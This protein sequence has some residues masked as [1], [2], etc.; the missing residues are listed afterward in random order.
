M[1]E[2]LFDIIKWYLI[3]LM[4]AALALCL[5]YYIFNYPMR[6]TIINTTSE[7]T[8]FELDRKTGEVWYLYPGSGGMKRRRVQDRY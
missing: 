1:K 8:V 5:I 6:Y 7:N 3:L 2:R 4:A